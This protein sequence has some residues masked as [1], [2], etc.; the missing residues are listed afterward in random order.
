M[1]WSSTQAAGTA[2]AA[3]YSVLGQYRARAL[4]SSVDPWQLLLEEF[5]VDAPALGRVRERARQAQTSTQDEIVAA[6]LVSETELYRVIARELDLAFVETIDPD[7]LVVRDRDCVAALS[8][9]KGIRMAMRMEG[10]RHAGVLIAPDLERIRGWLEQKPHMKQRLRVAPPSLLHA[11]FAE[12]ARPRLIEIARDGL[13]DR[14][15]ML[16]ARIVANAWQGAVVGALLVGLPVAFALAPLQSLLAVHMASTLFFLACVAL[17][18]AVVAA[19]PPL[20]APRLAALDR[21]RMPV[22]TVLVALYREAP[23]VPELLVSLGRL[24]WPRSR[25]QVRLVCESDDHETLAAIRAHGLRP[26]IEVIEVPPAGPRT[27]PKALS[28]A[29]PLTSGAFVALFD[30]EDR[31][32]P[33]QL[34]EAWQRFSAE[35]GDL[36]CLQAPLWVSNREEGPIARMFWF[37]YAALFRGLLPWLARRNLLLPLGGTSNHFRRRALEGVGG[38]D[39]YNVTED[40]DLG[41]RFKRFGYRVGT[42]AFA[43]GEDGPNDVGVWIRQRTRWFKGWLQSWLVHMRN[44]ARLYRDLGPRSFLVAQVLFA[45]MVASALVHPLL[46]VTGGILVWTMLASG[47]LGTIQRTLLMLDLVNIV[48]GYTAFL[49]MGFLTLSRRERGGFW[50]VVLLTPVYWMLMSV[51]AWRAVW[52]LYSRPHFW[53]KTP[54]MPS[55]PDKAGRDVTPESVVPRR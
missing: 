40:A 45:G 36:A 6:G 55:R 21:A 43:T 2:S 33:L 53:E 47:D 30:A 24:V 39:P 22:Y 46:L 35:G 20:N 25:L 48:A 44:P 18:G 10:N 51:A 13:F 12:R 7:S 34:I 1:G 23:V 8:S 37:E 38:W 4:P 9:D 41:M 14:F 15:P 54:H 32:H 29:L 52:Q 3:R 49:A 50:K 31:P 19:G 28:Y 42:I 17:R 27:K 26:F 16:S 11:A 5:G